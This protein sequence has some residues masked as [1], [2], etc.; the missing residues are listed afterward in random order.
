VILLYL[1]PTSRKI[2]Q[3]DPT[4][5]LAQ[6]ADPHFR[7]VAFELK[8]NVK[9]KNSWNSPGLGGY[10]GCWWWSGCC[11]CWWCSTRGGGLQGVVDDTGGRVEL[12]MSSI[13][14]AA[15]ATW[16]TDWLNAIET[17]RLSERAKPK[18]GQKWRAVAG[19][20]QRLHFFGTSL[21]LSLSPLSFQCERL[22]NVCAESLSTFFYF[23][24]LLLVPRAARITGAHTRIA[25]A[26]TAACIRNWYNRTRNQRDSP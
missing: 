11:C 17:L 24:G 26:Y 8:R 9:K 12:L 15:I 1:F 20:S 2:W 4:L 18:Q 23:R 25:S 5:E 6:E 10:W 16:N 21:S 7:R 13:L 14:M 19:S 3:G 22:Y